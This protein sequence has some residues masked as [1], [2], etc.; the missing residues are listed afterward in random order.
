[1]QRKSV[2]VVWTNSSID[3][4]WVIEEAQDGKERD[5][6]FPVFLDKVKAPRGFRLRHGAELSEGGIDASATAFQKLVAD[7]RALLGAPSQPTA[8]PKAAPKRSK[9]PRTPPRP[10]PATSAS[11]R[12]MRFGG[13]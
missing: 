1:M 3:S 2:L 9:P 6:L 4:E 7:L 10:P 8:K 5:I 12:R 11:G 13:S